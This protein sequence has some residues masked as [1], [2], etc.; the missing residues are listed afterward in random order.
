MKAIV[1]KK[2]VYISNP[3]SDLLFLRVQLC[4]SFFEVE[5]LIN[6]GFFVNYKLFCQFIM[7]NFTTNSDVLRAF[8]VKSGKVLKAMALFFAMLIVAPSVLAATQADFASNR[9]DFRDESIYF[10]MTTRFYDGDESNNVQCW[11]NQAANQNDPPWRGDFKG[12]IEKLDYIKALGF[13]AVWITPVVANGSGYDYHGYHAMDFSKVDPR[14]LS[15]DTDFQDLIDAAHA[16]GMKIVLDIVLQHTGNFGEEN[17]CK[18]F[19]RDYSANQSSIDD[20]MVPYTVSE[21]GKLPDNYLN[22]PSGEQYG[23]RLTQMKNQGGQN[24]D[25]HNYWHH[26]AN[27]NWDDPT[28]WFGQIAGDCVDLNTENPAVYNYL[29]ECYSKF[30]AMGVD[31]FRID[32]G[33]HI[34]RLTFNKAF[35]PGFIQAG[36]K[37]ASKRLN[38]MP[39]YMYAEVCARYSSIC[40]RE[41]ENLSPFYYTWAEDKNYD[42]DDDAASWDNIVAYEGDECK[43]HTN[44][45]SVWESADDDYG[46]LSSVSR[47]SQNALLNGND[48][49]TP[50]YSQSSGL[51]VIDFT[52]HHNFKDIGSA[53]NIAQPGNDKYYN[54]ATWNV[55]YVDSHDYA[56]NGAPED[57]RFA[58]GT[59]AWA[60]NLSLMF[61]HRGIPCLYYGSEIEFRAGYPIDKGTAAPISETGR[62]Y[63]GGYIK[64]GATVT[65][66]AEYTDATGNMAATLEAPLSKHIQQLN[67]IRQAVPA[68][69]KGQYSMTGCSGSY[70]FKRRYTDSKTDSYALVTIQGNAT[71][72]GIPNGIYQEVVTGETKTVT[73]GTLT[74]NCPTNAGNLRVWVLN[75]SLTSAPGKV[76]EDGKFIYSSSAANIPEPSY[77]G[78][79]E[80]AGTGES[81]SGS[82]GGTDVPGD[83]YTPSFNKGEYAVFFEA[84][85]D[86]SYAS[87]AVWVWNE[88][89]THFTGGTWPGERATAMG[90][91]A[92]GN[93]IWKWV[94][95][96]SEISETN[97]P[98]KI[99][100]SNFSGKQ[101]AD[102]IF[103]NG[104]YYTVDGLDHQIAA[105]IG[106]TSENCPIV[107]SAESN[108]YVMNAE[109]EIR[110]YSVDSQLVY[111]G[112]AEIIPVDHAGVYIVTVGDY[113]QKVMVK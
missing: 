74:A 108:I 43:S 63:F 44:W 93:V 56:P 67:K 12:L 54:D 87:V 65:D 111:Q 112:R 41:H 85:A 80:E 22:L 110:V 34:P 35:L 84:P 26:F 49:H 18:L 36:E 37:Y 76:V 16:K 46:D 11:D 106:E 55:V 68:L 104:G 24:N 72:S 9:T 2:Y 61:T 39:F 59:D 15:E 73:N 82:G 75:T 21:G 6:F 5:T 48:Y 71:F 107:Y 77:D 45:A 83:P 81:S 50:D 20:C 42:W 4:L 8:A 31:A 28:R 38:G 113:V 91:A 101:T 30:I 95:S 70:A 53:W 92:N 62:A 78:T 90:T 3:K 69:R 97:M 88:E 102:L 40:Y 58:Q 7:K 47:T 19:N 103:K 51:N 10:V 100:F 57:Q 23:A 1:D 52:M 64:G 29:I 17:L 96:G 109:N 14:Y 32:T 86:G 66:F 25:V 89:G 79:E 98:E 105:A 33:G 13:T 27:F 94:Y 60:S 99:I